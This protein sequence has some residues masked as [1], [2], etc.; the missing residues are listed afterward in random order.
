M[1]LTD[2]LVAYWKFDGDAVD[3]V[4][5]Y[6]GTVY[7][8]TN[9]V[10]YG[11]INQGYYFDGSNDYIDIGTQLRGVIGNHNFSIG[12]WFKCD[13]NNDNHR[14]YGH[15]EHLNDSKVNIYAK[16]TNQ[17][18]RFHMVRSVSGSDTGIDIETT[19]T[20]DFTNYHHIVVV[21]NGGTTV[22]ASDIKI[23][24]DNVDMPTTIVCDND[25]LSGLDP[26]YKN[27]VF[28]TYYSG[29]YWKG[30]MDEQFI[31]S[32]ALS[33]SE[34]SELYNSGEGLQYPFITPTINEILIKYE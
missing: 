28:G 25:T 5:A 23:Y 20:I 14:F 18:F 29:Y 8:A 34:M 31:Y 2:G 33:S 6:N 11:K 19:S 1:A 12:G 16:T 24:V 22:T 26:F 30:S 9:G 7:G 32:R 27:F 13:D 17:K 4:N 3:A 21:V 10:A 15:S